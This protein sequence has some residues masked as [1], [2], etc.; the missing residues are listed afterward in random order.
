MIIILIISNIAFWVLAL[1]TGKDSWLITIFAHLIYAVYK[2]LTNPKQK[3]DLDSV[4]LIPVFGIIF[5]V[6]GLIF[7]GGP[8]GSAAL[9]LGLHSVRNNLKYGIGGVVLGTISLGW[10][11]LLMLLAVASEIEE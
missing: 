10:S 4:N 8:L 7:F 2:V 6:L 5:G 11:V 9:I 1:I 3:Y